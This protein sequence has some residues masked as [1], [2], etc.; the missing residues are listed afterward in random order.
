MFRLILSFF[1]FASICGCAESGHFEIDFSKKKTTIKMIPT[2]YLTT[3][4]YIEI[5][6][7]IDCDVRILIP[8][9][10]SIELKKGEINYA[11]RHEWF[12]NGKIIQILNEGCS[13]N[14]KL[15]IYYSYTAS[16]W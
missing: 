16:Y 5:R 13:L 9:G 11:K 15:I 6:G 3:W 14:S 8:G 4:N 10:N 7:Q 1:I 12:D 2:R